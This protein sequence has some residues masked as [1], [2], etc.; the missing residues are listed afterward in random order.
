MAEPETQPARVARVC[1]VVLGGE[2]M[3]V[4]VRSVREVVE[5][6]NF[7]V[8]PAAPARLL[9]VA[10]LRGQA[11]PLLDAGPTLGVA[12]HARRDQTVVLVVEDG[13][14]PVGFVVDR[15]LGLD[16][17]DAVQ[18]VSATAPPGQV[19]FGLGVACCGDHQGLILDVVKLV[20]ALRM[21]AE[22]KD[23]SC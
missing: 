11:L 6:D 3:A 7:T 20:R 14:R 2:R 21:S 10:N 1:S 17:V 12:A 22:G 18:A 13:G 15:V 4:D 8:V 5:L 23:P 9:G 19:A 16:A